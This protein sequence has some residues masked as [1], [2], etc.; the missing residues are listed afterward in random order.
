MWKNRRGRCGEFLLQ[1][2]LFSLQNSDSFF[3]VE[4]YNAELAPAH[5]GGIGVAE[6]VSANPV[7][8]NWRFYAYDHKKNG[9]TSLNLF[10]FIDGR[11]LC[12][13]GFNPAREKYP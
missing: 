1:R 7:V 10:V 2:W 6:I 4:G 8:K 5:E 3:T 13:R 9:G 11:R 12:G